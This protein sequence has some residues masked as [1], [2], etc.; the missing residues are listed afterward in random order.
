MLAAGLIDWIMPMAPPGATW[1][2]LIGGILSLLL[3]QFGTRGSSDADRD[4]IAVVGHSIDDIMIGAAET[5]YFVD[6]VKKKIHEDV[7][8]AVRIAASAGEIATSTEQ[9]A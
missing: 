6:S 7:E 9:I 8:I 1:G 4:I 5:S 2:A 3:F